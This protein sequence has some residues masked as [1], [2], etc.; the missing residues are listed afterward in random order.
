MK[1]IEET[2]LFKN[3]RVSMVLK[4][5]ISYA[6]A[7]C[8][9][10]NHTE[11]DYRWLNDYAEARGDEMVKVI[12]YL[13]GKADSAMRYLGTLTTFLGLILAYAVGGKSVPWSVVLFL[14][15]VLGWMFLAVAYSVYCTRPTL[16]P[17]RPFVKQAFSYAQE[18]EEGAQLYFSRTWIYLEFRLWLMGYQKG[19][20]VASSLYSFLFA[21]GFWMPV[22]LLGLLYRQAYPPPTCFPLLGLE[23]SVVAVGVFSAILFAVYRRWNLVHQIPIEDWLEQFPEI[24]SS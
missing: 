3:P 23:S 18:T 4:R 20:F 6:T 8:I 22:G 17:Q 14:L 15:P 9:R 24:L 2:G 19:H 5:A 16:Q 21:L 7:W 10:D 13:D 1:N 11:E 12:E